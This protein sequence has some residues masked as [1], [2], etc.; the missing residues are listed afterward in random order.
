MNIAQFTTV[1]KIISIT[2][3]FSMQ[4][5]TL[6]VGEYF[7]GSTIKRIELELMHIGNEADGAL[8]RLCFVGYGDMNKLFYYLATSVNVHFK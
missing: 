1:D 5:L 4:P 7:N 6:R 3:A 2:E 8:R